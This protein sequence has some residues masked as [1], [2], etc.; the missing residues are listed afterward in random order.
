MWRSSTLLLG[1]Y[2]SAC[3]APQR[4]QPSASP[5][6]P[7]AE[8]SAWMSG[9]FSSAA[10]HQQDPQS[11]HE[12]VL[13]MQPIWTARSDGP[14]LY[15][16]QALA[17]KQERPY[18]QRVYRLRLGAAGEVWSDVYTLPQDPLRFAGAWQEPKRLDELDPAQLVFR[19]GCSLRLSRGADGAWS[20]ATQGKQCPSELSGA[21]Y[22][23]SEAR[24]EA[25]L[26]TSWDRGYDERDQQ[27]W[28]AV[29]GPYRFVKQ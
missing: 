8:L 3:A 11:Y 5:L 14:W 29:H 16:E 19:E 22:A 25:Q 9:S 1:L 26:L 24:V 12:I 6:P 10:Q 18:R 27:V 23:T 4:G 7:L 2:L 13:H 15:V 20:G 17:T 21:R 28:G